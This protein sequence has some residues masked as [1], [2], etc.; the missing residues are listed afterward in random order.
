MRFKNVLIPLLLLLS[1]SPKLQAQ[2]EPLSVEE[3]LALLEIEMDSL[4]IFNLIDSIISGV[5]DPYSELNVRMSY[6]SN[7]VSS[8]RN[9]NIDQ[10]GVSPGISYYHKKGFYADISG[11][12]NSDFDP[13]YSLTVASLG[14]LKTYGK[15]WLIGG[16]YERWIY[17]QRGGE[18]IFDPSI[19][20]SLNASLGFNTKPIYAS[21]DYNYLFGSAKAH[22]II[23]SISGNL[24]FK[25]VWAFDRIRIAPSFSM[26]YGNSDVLSHYFT[27]Q[28]QE[29]QFIKEVIRSPE[30]RDLLSTTDFSEEERRARLNIA[31]QKLPRDVKTFQTYN[32]VYSQNDELNNYIE[33][34]LYETTNQYGLMNYNLSLP[35]I[36]SINPFNFI[37]SY[38]YS[39]PLKLPGEE[40]KPDA[41]GFFGASVTYRLPFR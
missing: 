39:V 33:S 25:K 1:C 16:S 41:I 22:R 12:W 26:I 35:I 37:L 29:W 5:S 18:T 32:Q 3:Q 34:Q 23:G 2:N 17:N 36:F 8:G 13:N 15:H 11:F 38:T 10:H 14:F 7:V 4:S 20:N 9:F 30:F 31:R 19:K 24:S 28:R 6:N 40:E 27:D 21:L